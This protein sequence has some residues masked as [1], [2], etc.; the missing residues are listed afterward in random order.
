M[1]NI[2]NKIKQNYKLIIAL[3]LVGSTIGFAIGKSNSNTSEIA[4]IQI[5]EHEH[6]LELKNG[7]WTCSMHPQIKQKKSGDCPICGMDLI[8]MK[9][10][11]STDLTNPNEIQLTES[12][13][14]L[15]QVQTVIV[16]R[17]VPK[18]EIHLQGKVKA[19]E[20]NI[21]Q[22]TARFG[23]RIEKLTIN[24]TGQKVKKG[25]ILAT[26][27]SP[28]L[29][30]AQTE[31]LE[32]VNYKESNPSIYKASRT[33]LKLWNLND[34]Q[35]DAIENEGKAKLYFDIFSPISGTVSKRKVSVGN[36]IKEGA[37]LFEIIDLSNVWLIFDAYETDLPWVKIGDKINFTLQAIPGKKFSAKITFINPFIDATTR[38]STLRAEIRNSNFIFKPEMFIN[39]ILQSE[40]AKNTNKLLVPKSAILWTGK[41]AIVYIKVP[42]RKI[43]TF[44]FREI[45]LGAEAGNFYVVSK[46]LKEGDEIVANGVFKIDASAQ[47]AGKKSMMNPNG[48]KISTGHNHGEQEVQGK[49][50]EHKNTKKSENIITKLENKQ[51]KNST[52]ETPDAFKKQIGELINAYLKLKDALVAT[53]EKLA[54]TEATKVLLALNNVDMNLLKGDAHKEWMMLFKTI[55]NNLNGIISMEGMEMKRSHFSIVSNKLTETIEMY[56]ISSENTIYL[57]FCSMAFDF[58]GA[59]WISENKEIRNPYFGDKMLKCGE[60]KKEFN[61]Q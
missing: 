3:L 25:Q 57:E 46:G 27:Y 29:I 10:I 9:T 48:E 43:P 45:T 4:K 17:G 54:E 31:L 50:E 37:I 52:Q 49:N 61:N 13:I 42:N 51:T 55:K 14:K 2:L 60:V 28:D 59:Y 23:G 5:E 20:R 22:L 6:D 8:P 56:G 38:V 11:E 21:A 34:E 41:R 44:I 18:K 24:Y 30:T 32:A 12:A 1:K 15:A 16:K 36:Y 35:I 39:G 58:K 19:D 7:T 47:L 33:K 40:I 26:I 53:N